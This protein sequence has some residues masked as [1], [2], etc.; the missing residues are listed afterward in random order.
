MN[1]GGLGMDKNFMGSHSNLLIL[2]LISRKDMYGYEII[3]ELEVLSDQSF[4]LKEG[5]LYPILHKLE[6]MKWVSSYMTLTENNIKRK[7]YKITQLGLQ[8]FAEEKQTWDA[9]KSSIV[10]VL[11]G[12]KYVNQTQE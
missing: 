11:G 10:K 1:I 7:Y 9:Y 8:Q 4:Q 5:T 3:K 2:S 12:Q 6:N